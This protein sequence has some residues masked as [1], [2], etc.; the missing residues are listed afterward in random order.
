VAP[1]APAPEAA[2]P[3]AA[4]RLFPH[5]EPGAL[6]A[7]SPPAF[8]YARLLEDGTAED[9]AWLVASQGE[10]ALAAWLAVRG[11]RSLSRRSRAFW[12]LLLGIRAAPPPAAAHDLW[13]LG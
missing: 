11:G 13:P 8:L 9:L 6:L 3:Q 7:L 4:A 5:H 12:E 2:L 1:T 10:A